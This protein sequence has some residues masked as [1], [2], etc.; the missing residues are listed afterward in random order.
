MKDIDAVFERL[1]TDADFQMALSRD[2]GEAL[3]HYDL[4]DDDLE[5][6]SPQIKPGPGEPWMPA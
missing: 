3:R 1:R 6:L 4:S 2:P 5:Q